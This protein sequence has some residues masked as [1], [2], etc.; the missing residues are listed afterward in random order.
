MSFSKL[1][2]IR[3]SAKDSDTILTSL[4]GSGVYFA[5]SSPPSYREG[6]PELGGSAIA[7]CHCAAQRNL[8]ELE[9]AQPISLPQSE[10][11]APACI[12]LTHKDSCCF[13]TS[14]NTYSI[15][16]QG[17]ANTGELF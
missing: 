15:D 13:T 10:T 16:E 1:I 11:P 2:A 14:S 17:P 7:C 12:S 3:H 8:G 6:E 5:Q 4:A 9:S